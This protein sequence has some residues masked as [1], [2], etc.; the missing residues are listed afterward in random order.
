MLYA[1]VLMSLFFVMT[2]ILTKPSVLL[3]LLDILFIWVFQLRFLLMV[4]P[5]YFAAST[6]FSVWLCMK[7]LDLTELFERVIWSTWH[8]PGLKMVSEYDQEIPQSQTAD[9]PIAPRGRATQSSRDCELVWAKVKIQ[10]SND[11]RAS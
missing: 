8:L 7:Y 10:G 2:I 9:N 3:A 11:S 5:R 1:I 4:A 6:Y